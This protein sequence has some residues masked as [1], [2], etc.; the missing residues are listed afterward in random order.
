[1]VDS[2]E[3]P[4]FWDKMYTTGLASFFCAQKTV[5]LPMTSRCGQNMV[6][7]SRWLSC[8]LLIVANLMLTFFFFCHLHARFSPLA[9]LAAQL[10]NSTTI[11]VAEPSEG[12]G[13]FE[14]TGGD[15]GHTA[16]HRDDSYF[17]IRAEELEQAEAN[18]VAVVRFWIPLE[19]I[20][21]NRHKMEFVAGA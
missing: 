5:M 12:M 8:S 20:P 3:H 1:M 9:S 7:A 18:G 11:R 13:S 15:C 16:Y 17:P 2:F 19:E 4:T 6:S 14:A 10:L 21:R